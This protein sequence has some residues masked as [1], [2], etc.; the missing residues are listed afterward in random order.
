MGNEMTRGEISQVRSSE[1]QFF[2]KLYKFFAA[3]AIILVIIPFVNA[4]VMIPLNVPLWLSLLLLPLPAL[5]GYGIQHLFGRVVKVKRQYISTGYDGGNRYFMPHSAALPMTLAGAASILVIP[6]G[7]AYMRLRAE[8]GI[9]YYYDSESLYPYLAA[10]SFFAL[11]AAGIV[12]WF[13]PYY[14]LVTMKTL[15]PCLGALLICFIIS[16]S[17][18]RCVT[19]CAVFYL[20]FAMLTL[21][22]TALLRSVDKT[23]VGVVTVGMRLYNIALT[24]LLMLALAGTLVLITSALVGIVV[25]ARMLGYMLLSAMFKDTETY[26]DADTVSQAVGEGVFNLKSFG[27]ESQNGSRMYFMIFCVALLLLAVFF[28]VARKR[29]TFKKII[30]WFGALYRSIVEFFMLLFRRDRHESEDYAR[31]SDYRDT[32]IKHTSAQIREYSA[33]K[34]KSGAVDYREFSRRLSALKSYPEKLNYAYNTLVV[35]WNGLNF[36]LK[37]SDTPR[38][39]CEKV[40]FRSELEGIGGITGAFELTKY[41]GKE[42]DNGALESIC[43]LVKKYLD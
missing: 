27:I 1:E 11:A 38:Q 6:A 18:S 4:I 13:Y 25:I 7:K 39:I 41:A 36:A 16:M 31:Y 32:E 30:D 2:G 24:V 29:G 35:C 14:R 34:Q 12:V 37:A 40:E 8:A 20:T 26:E 42:E 23:K 22:Q 10:I 21:N 19:I 43:S 33:E 3:S 9:D 15:F 17:D 5:F 28:I